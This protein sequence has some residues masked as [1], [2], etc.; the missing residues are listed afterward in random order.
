MCDKGGWVGQV[1]LE[2]DERDVT[3]IKRAHRQNHWISTCGLK[4]SKRVVDWEKQSSAGE[5]RNLNQIEWNY[6]F[7]KQD[8]E[9][10]KRYLNFKATIESQRR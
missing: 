6:C 8:Q 4:N 9:A 2:T 1:F 10:R 3:K 5:G 7:S